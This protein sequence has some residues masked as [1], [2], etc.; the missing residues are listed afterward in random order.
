MFCQNT[1]PFISLLFHVYI[2]YAASYQNSQ[3]TQNEND[4]NNTTVGTWLVS[5]MEI[6]FA[7]HVCDL[8]TFTADICGQFGS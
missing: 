1:S 7:Q 4:P 2:L 6:S 8:K 5:C 3:G